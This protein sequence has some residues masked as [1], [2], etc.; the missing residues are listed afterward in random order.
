MEPSYSSLPLYI[1]DASAWSHVGSSVEVTTYIEGISHSGIMMTCPPA[2]LEYCFMARDAGEHDVFRARMTKLKQ[3]ERD[4]RV[5]DV[6]R[7]QSALWGSG[8]V[9]AA[10]SMNT[11]I[12]SYA[13]LHAA[14][15]VSCDK[16]YG[17]IS[18]ALGNELKYVLL[19][20]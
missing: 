9:R 14:T 12:A 17:H 10:G 19:R 18:R 8:L 13:L 3:P 11:L 7:V 2:S 1:V 20:P 15:V 16:D 6:L 5:E 4:P